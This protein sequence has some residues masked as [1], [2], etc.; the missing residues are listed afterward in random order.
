MQL[1]EMPLQTAPTPNEMLVHGFMA[2]SP[3][4]ALG[5]LGPAF[6]PTALHPPMLGS[7]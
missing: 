2:S 5:L 3:I 7:P 1:N 6:V 4:G